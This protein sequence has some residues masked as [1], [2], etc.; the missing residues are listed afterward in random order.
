M[1]GSAVFVLRTCIYRVENVDTSGAS[2][3]IRPTTTTMEYRVFWSKEKFVFYFC[4][5]GALRA[6]NYDWAVNL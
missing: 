1:H 2:Y 6:G 4:Y 5:K 3:F